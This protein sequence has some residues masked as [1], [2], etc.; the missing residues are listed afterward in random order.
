MNPDHLALIPRSNDLNQQMELKDK[1]LS[2]PS[3]Y[4]AF[5]KECLLTK[6]IQGTF[7]DSEDAPEWARKIA[8]F[9]RDELRDTCRNGWL[10]HDYIADNL[11]GQGKGKRAVNY[12]HAMNVDSTI[13]T[14]SQQYNNCCA[15]AVRE[16][17]GFCLAMDIVGR[18]EL[19]E[20]TKRPG[21]AG[22]YANRGSRADQGMTLSD[23]AAA[24]HQIGI[25]LETEY[26]GYDLSTQDLDE[27]AGVKWGAHGIPAALRELV[28]GNLI[29]QVSNV[30][31]KEA[32]QDILYG[33]HCIVTGSTRTANDTKPGD[34]ISSLTRIGGHAQLMIGY[35]DTDEFRDWYYQTTG[36]RLNDWVGIFDQSWGDWLEINN[37]PIQFWGPR[38]QGAF[39][40]KG[41]DAMELI[42]IWGEAL[43]F[44]AVKGFDLLELPDWGSGGYL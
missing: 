29:E 20:Y 12:Q 11:K 23:G 2:S 30:Q 6:S 44:N 9:A 5:V 28:Q 37:W 1:R 38:P 40:L 10:A 19:H 33:G 8:R 34:P 14:G 31:E 3:S 32:V 18:H 39:V 13:F 4:P 15:W 21:T 43:A 16:G 42:T 17:A 35:D 24:V 27:S 22:P 26:P 7:V 36:N 41:S 25:T